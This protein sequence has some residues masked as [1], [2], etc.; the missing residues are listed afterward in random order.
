VNAA[1]PAW[2]V[3]P[4]HELD[5]AERTEYCA[6][7]V[8]NAEWLVAGTFAHMPAGSRALAIVRKAANDLRAEANRVRSAPTDLIQ[9]EAPRLKVVR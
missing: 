8:S 2:L 3:K 7:L 4:A 9:S 5:A 1:W 6:F